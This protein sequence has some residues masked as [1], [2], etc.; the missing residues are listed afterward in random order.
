MP[1]KP[2][3]AN[4][5]VAGEKHFEFRRTRIR[6]DLTHVVIYSSAPV[7][8]IVGL[9]E[10][11]SVVT[12]TPA[13]LWERTKHSAGISR[14][15]FREYFFGAQSAVAISLKRVY[16]IN[17]ELRPEDIIKGFSIPQSFRYV[18]RWFI[19]KVIRLGCIL[20]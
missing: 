19:E 2:E 1:V 15:R 8:R 3:Y 11:Q 16:P 12:S 13:K 7:K 20:G 4:R 6:R 10:V 17:C 18:D 9:A 14:Q 5:I